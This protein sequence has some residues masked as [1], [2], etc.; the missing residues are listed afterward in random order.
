M[1]YDEDRKNRKV[2]GGADQNEGL[3]TE[4]LAQRGDQ[5]VY[6]GDAT[7]GWEGTQDVQVDERQ[8]AQG[9]ADATQD[10]SR[11][12][13]VPDEDAQNGTDGGGRFDE[14]RFDDDRFDD[15]RPGTVRPDAVRSDTSADAGAGAAAGSAA[16]DGTVGGQGEE[17][18][19]PRGDA[20]EL[21]LRWSEVQGR[22]V[23]DP[24]EAVRSADQLVAEVMQTLAGTFAT[25]K[26]E[27][28]GQWSQGQPA[29]EDL[30]LALQHYRS[31]F[32]RLLAT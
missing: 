32:N 15:D 9:A 21:R 10:G 8:D 1:Q 22:F 29:T 5:A 26:Q 7:K 2:V 19:L 27:L 30:R 3:T 25:R 13:D 14:G 18:L 23:D 17:A 28:E 31:F 11:V 12:R 20:E 4:S 6:P 24:Q 16:A